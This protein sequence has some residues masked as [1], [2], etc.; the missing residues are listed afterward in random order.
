MDISKDI[1]KDCI[2]KDTCL[3]RSEIH[4]YNFNVTECDNI[5][6][7][8]EIETKV[9]LSLDRNITDSEEYY[10]VINNEFYLQIEKDL[11]YRLASYL[12]INVEAGHE[13]N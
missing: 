11:W 6:K 13:K 2:K 4:Y 12:K 10:A 1:C 9:N 7:D 8:F 3:E 5:L